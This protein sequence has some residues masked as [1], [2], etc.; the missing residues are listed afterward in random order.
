MSRTGIE[1]AL[2]LL[3]NETRFDI[4]RALASQQFEEPGASG[5]T[6]SDLFAEAATDDSGNFN[7]HLNRLL[8]RLVVKEGECY[9]LTHG[10]IQ[11]FSLLQATTYAPEHEHR[12]IQLD[13]NCPLCPADLSA[14]YREGYLEIGCGDHLVLEIYVPPS[15]IESRSTDAFL[16]CVSLLFHHHIEKIAASICPLCWGALGHGLRT[17]EQPYPLQYYYPCSQCGTELRL[18]P[19]Q[20]VMHHREVEAF[21]RDRGIELRETPPWKLYDTYGEMRVL[22]GADARV[23]FELSVKGDTTVMTVD[24]RSNLLAFEPEG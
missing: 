14:T 8:D 13:R 16:D 21:Y 12:T 22:P 18:V 20:T 7:Y 4:L 24:G 3:S 15:W 10:G 11:L 1:S 5:M 23:E 17:D 6:F 19:P 9:R 2:D